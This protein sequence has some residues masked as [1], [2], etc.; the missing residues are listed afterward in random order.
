MGC[1]RDISVCKVTAIPPYKFDKAVAT[2]TRYCCIFCL[3]ATCSDRTVK[4]FL[5]RIIEIRASSPV[6]IVL[7]WK[8]RYTF[9]RSRH[10]LRANHATERSWRSSS[11]LISW[12]MLS[13]RRG[14]WPTRDKTKK[15][16]QCEGYSFLESTVSGTTPLVPKQKETWELN[17]LSPCS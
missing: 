12:P 10:S 13:I 1:G 4:K 6:S 15:W 17:L 9:E 5:S 2:L 7:R 16:R 14:F 11:S 8:R 3:S